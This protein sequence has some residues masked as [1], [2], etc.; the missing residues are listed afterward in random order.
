MT[1]KGARSGNKNT[2]VKRIV[3]NAQNDPVITDGDCERCHFNGDLVGESISCSICCRLFHAL[4]RDIKGAFNNSSI[5]SKSFFDM[6]GPLAAHYKQNASRWGQFLF[7]CQN[8]YIDYPGLFPK[9]NDEYIDVVKSPVKCNF[10]HKTNEAQTVIS[11]SIQG[12]VSE[13]SNAIA[14]E[15]SNLTKLNNQIL[16]NIKSLEKLSNENA[17]TFS[18]K[19]DKLTNQFL[20]GNQTDN[21]PHSHNSSPN[22]HS[23]IP[24]P[25]AVVSPNFT[26]DA[27]QI[28]PHKDFQENFL[29]DEMLKDLT[30]FLG[31]SQDFSTINSKKS[32]GSRDVAYYGEFNYR[33]GASQH[34]AKIIPNSIKPIVELLAE[35]YPKTI[36]N[37]CLVTR[38]VNGSNICPKHSDDEPFIAPCS[39]IFTLSIGAERSMLFNSVNGESNAIALPSNSL[40]A[41]SR[42]SQE[43]WQHEIPSCDCSTI[44]YSLTFRQLAPFYANSTIIVGDSNTQ[45]LKFGAGR[46]TFGIWMPGC[47]VKAGKIDDIPGTNDLDFP[48]RN[49]VI[50]TGINDLRGKNH[51]PINTLISKLEFKCLA[52]RSKFKHMKF[53]ISMLLP[54]KDPGLNVLVSQFN[55]HI[56]L[57]TEKYD[58][59]F[60]ISH[61]NLANSSGLL[62]HDLGRHNHDGSA[63]TF[64]AVHLGSKGTSIFCA[65]I[66]NC[67]VKSKILKNSS[68]PVSYSKS[69]NIHTSKFEYWNPNPGYIP[70]NR[71]LIPHKYPWTNDHDGNFQVTSPQSFRLDSFNNGYQS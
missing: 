9:N 32:S 44:R 31:Q 57:L 5:C 33:Y 25:N 34:A 71:P 54:T 8:C 22:N 53:F 29:S 24:N 43:F 67:I 20:S 12:N 38:Y 39:D 41:F 30:D 50:H 48:Y 21:V 47:R 37:S 19:I 7:I 35:K 68:N 28:T 45:N 3:T 63:L 51:Q 60:M 66:K 59:M 64:D 11:G 61:H 58:F 55:H 2:K 42:A 49:F 46:S 62:T 10:A 23:P 26:F 27:E 52:L 16:E 4:C 1:N 56:K 15:I 14:D 70:S 13:Y 6:F 40:L 17:T 69:S 65:N 18:D 36:I